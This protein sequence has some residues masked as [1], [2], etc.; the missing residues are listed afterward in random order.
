VCCLG[1]V[2]LTTSGHFTIKMRSDRKCLQELPSI[3]GFVRRTCNEEP[4]QPLDRPAGVSSCAWIDVL[5]F[6]RGRSAAG[7][8][9]I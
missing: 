7:R 1:K 9:A 8:S 4:N 3:R 6:A 2:G 5:P